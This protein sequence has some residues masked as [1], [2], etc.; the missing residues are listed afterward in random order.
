MLAPGGEGSDNANQLGTSADGLWPFLKHSW[1]GPL[2]CTLPV[3]SACWPGGSS[4]CCLILS[5]PSHKCPNAS[6]PH[7][8]R[9]RPRKHLPWSHSHPDAW[10]AGIHAVSFQS[11]LST[12]QIYHKA[13][14]TKEKRNI[15]C[16]KGTEKFPHSSL[17]FVGLCH[18]CVFVM[19]H[20]VL[21]LP[22]FLHL[23]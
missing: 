19:F 6:G 17:I 22:S 15:S 13:V 9:I 8:S 12:K 23:H 18:S 21:S 7:T 20:D 14:I 11:L 16:M 2:P 3:W 1:P 10:F 4:L 5:P